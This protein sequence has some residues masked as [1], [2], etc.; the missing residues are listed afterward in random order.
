MTDSH[1]TACLER[2]GG[3]Q[4]HAWYSPYMLGTPPCTR[5][6]SPPPS[7]HRGIRHCAS[8]WTQPARRILKWVRIKSTVLTEPIKAVGCG[9]TCPAPRTDRSRRTG[10]SR[11]CPVRSAR[12]GASCGPEPKKR[13]KEKGKEEKKQPKSGQSPRQR[14]VHRIAGTNQHPISITR[15]K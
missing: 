5:D 9:I 6:S 3:A 1:T 13:G 10:S 14:R 11:E 4:R 7:S 8:I 2:W 15:Q 12:G